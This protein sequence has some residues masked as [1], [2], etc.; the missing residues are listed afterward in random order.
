[1]FSVVFEKIVFH[2][3]LSSVFSKSI[4]LHFCDAT[5]PSFAWCGRTPLVTTFR[6]NP[7]SILCYFLFRF[8][9]LKYLY[10]F[11]IYNLYFAINFFCIS[12]RKDPACSNFSHKPHLH[13]VFIGREG[14]NHPNPFV[15]KFLHK[16]IC[17]RMYLY[18]NIFL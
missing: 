14:K 10:F 12:V 1:M 11:F 9:Y 8:L 16:S 6:I 7:T 13:L 15:R 17:G 2:H 3:D 18:T 4:F 5:F